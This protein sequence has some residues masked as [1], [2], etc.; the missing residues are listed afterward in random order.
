MSKKNIHIVPADSGW[1][2]KR[3]GQSQPLSQH[4]TQ[5]NADKAGRPIARRDGVELVTH[6]RDGKIRD[7]DSFGPDP[8]PPIDHKH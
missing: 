6:G 3:E 2:V 4:R 7:S 5:Q 8:H 1:A